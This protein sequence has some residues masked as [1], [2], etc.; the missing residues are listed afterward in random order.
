MSKEQIEPFGDDLLLVGGIHNLVGEGSVLVV[1]VVVVRP[2][3]QTATSTL[4]PADQALD[5]P[6]PDVCRSASSCCLL[7]LICVHLM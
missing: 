1:A 7:H 5:T 3:L 6:Q 2:L 4:P